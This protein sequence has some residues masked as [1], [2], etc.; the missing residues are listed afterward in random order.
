MNIVKIFSS[1]HKSADTYQFLNIQTCYKYLVCFKSKVYKIECSQC[2]SVYT[3][4]TKRNYE[5]MCKGF[6]CCTCF[7]FNSEYQR[8]VV[9]FYWQYT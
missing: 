7:F 9:F 5:I 2:N 4:Q 8:Q 3:E 1:K 6:S